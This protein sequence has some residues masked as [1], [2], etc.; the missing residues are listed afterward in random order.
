[1][2]KCMTSSHGEAPVALNSPAVTGVLISEDALFR[3]SIPA[4]AV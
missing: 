4:P 2:L 3:C 1:M